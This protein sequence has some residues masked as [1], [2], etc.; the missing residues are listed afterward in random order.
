MVLITLK[1]C[2]NYVTMTLNYQV[3]AIM[4]YN[5][6]QAKYQQGKGLHSFFFLEKKHES[7]IDPR[8]K[9]VA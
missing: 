7:L 9:P 1:K 6:V 4:P 2:A 3:G 8:L 5:L